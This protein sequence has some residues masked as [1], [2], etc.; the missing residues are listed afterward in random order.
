MNLPLTEILR[1]KDCSEIVGQDHLCGKQGLIS[2]AIDKKIPLSFV[3]WGEPGTGKTSII[4][5]YLSKQKGEVLRVTGST[6]SQK[7]AK[8]FCE[9]GEKL[10]NFNGTPSFIFI[11]E[12]HRL[13][14]SQQ[15]LFLHYVERGAVYLLG[16]TTENPSFELNKA[17]ISRIK[18]FV[19]NP[20]NKDSV[21]KIL[22]RVINYLN[23]K[24]NTD[25]DE[26]II[27]FLYSVYGSD[28]RSAINSLDFIRQ[29]KIKGKITVKKIEKIISEK[30][31]FYDKD[32]EVHYN[33]ISALHKSIRNSD[34]DASLYWLS[35]MLIAGEDRKYILRRL[36]RISAEDIGLADPKAL[37]IALNSLRGF[38]FLG[39][40]E[41]DIFLFYT[42][43]YLA[44]APKSNSLYKAEIKSKN[45]AK[46][47]S[48]EPIPLHLRNPET[49]LMKD[50][51]YGEGYQYA[52]DFP[53]KT[54][55]METLP[56]ELRRL[57]LFYPENIGF[58]KQILQRYEYWKK[59][60]EKLKK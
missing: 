34:I 55:V 8:L 17:L 11:D 36:I 29:K 6:F 16:A 46:Q 19:L 59:L 7:E 48:N 2:D 60:K 27:D 37:D 14:K 15:D 13:N 56:K 4:E 23:K 12:I 20:L 1:P 3:L 51:G 32:G 18:I 21:F 42:T 9:K 50:A 58:E 26:N 22:K 5:I 43:V 41:G 25:F 54:T 44:L 10:K 49:K 39:E 30:K 31:T 53:E 52:H 24:D 28:V 33:I 47:T 45:I 38:E 35:R 40:P 57:T